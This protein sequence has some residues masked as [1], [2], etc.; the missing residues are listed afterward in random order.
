ME[1]LSE[2]YF[3]SNEDTGAA[4]RS[5]LLGECLPECTMDGGKLVPIKVYRIHVLVD[6]FTGEEASVRG[7]PWRQPASVAEAVI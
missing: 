6:R 5:R 3:V 4:F 7:I 2:S 1:G